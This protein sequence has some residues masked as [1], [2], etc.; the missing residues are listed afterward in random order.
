MMKFA[1]IRQ[2]RSLAFAAAVALAAAL[3]GAGMI[4]AAHAAPAIIPTVLFTTLNGP[5]GSASGATATY[6]VAVQNSP[7]GSTAANVVD[8]FGIHKTDGSILS[9]NAPGATCNILPNAIF[10]VV[11]C[12]APGLAVG[13]EIDLTVNVMFSGKTGIDQLVGV[14]DASNA[15]QVV[16]TENVTVV[17][18]SNFGGEAPGP[19]YP[20]THGFGGGN[21]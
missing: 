16:A 20:G 7:F 8:E 9:Y 21:A 3:P 12:T 17:A 15:T 18:Q 13:A 6:V 1:A 14:G 10:N 11:K 4:S 19:L 5:S 2:S